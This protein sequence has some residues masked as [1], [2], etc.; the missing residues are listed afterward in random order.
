[1]KTK[2]HS[3]K[4]GLRMSYS[5]PN[6][7]DGVPIKITEVRGENFNLNFT[8]NKENIGLQK[9]KPPAVIYNLPTRIIQQLSKAEVPVAF[10]EY[11]FATEHEIIN[12]AN[13]WIQW[14]AREKLERQQRFEQ[15][16]FARSKRLEDEQKQKLN[17]V[18]YPSSDEEDEENSKKAGNFSKTPQEKPFI[19]A[20]F[21]T[22]LMPTMATV[23]EKKTH[24]RYASN[25]SNKID[26]SFFESDASPFDHLEMKSM[27]EMEVLAQVLGSTQI[28]GSNIHRE[29][30]S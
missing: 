30:S 25:S 19:Q 11:N 12:K 7:T 22:I 1:M 14:R 20:N 5:T 17:Q 21:N 26:F 27:N 18:S 10:E 28:E 3:D 23:Q 8:M 15:R 4:K 13:E 2:R 24:H 29:N 16:E 9:Y 6:Y